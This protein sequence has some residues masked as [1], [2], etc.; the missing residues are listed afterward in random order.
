MSDSPE[1]KVIAAPRS[2]GKVSFMDLWLTVLG[3]AAFRREQTPQFRGVVQ[4]PMSPR[5][6]ARSR[7]FQNARAMMYAAKLAAATKT[8]LRMETQPH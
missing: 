5:Q 6:Y 4:R 8:G 3:F 7:G 2:P 1:V